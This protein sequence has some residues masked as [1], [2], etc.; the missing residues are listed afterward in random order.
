M[1]R[2]NGRCVWSGGGLDNRTKGY[3]EPSRT[4]TYAR[5]LTIAAVVM[6]VNSSR[7]RDYYI[8]YFEWVGEHSEQGNG[9]SNSTCEFI[10]SDHG[11]IKDGKLPLSAPARIKR[12]AHRLRCAPGVCGCIARMQC[13]NLNPNQWK[14]STLLSTRTSAVEFHTPY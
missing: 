14:S 2:R 6:V 12:L 3:T 13:T 5:V 9:K 7:R 8:I 4:S 1:I 10:I 11:T